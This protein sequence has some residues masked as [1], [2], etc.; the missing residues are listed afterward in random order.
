MT[1]A[2]S[3]WIPTLAAFAVRVMA[4]IALITTLTDFARLQQDLRMYF[5]NRYADVA[6][7]RLPDVLLGAALC[8]L[9]AL[10]APALAAWSQRGAGRTPG[11]GET[12]DRASR[13]VIMTMATA[14]LL[15]PLVRAP[16]AVLLPLLGYG[17]IPED[18]L[19]HMAYLNEPMLVALIAPIV[20]LLSPVLGAAL[21]AARRAL[22]RQA[23]T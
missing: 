7:E 3:V 20:I 14:S 12:I 15:I 17:D 16:E 22:Q 4:L 19:A 18:L 23:Y 9:L 10:L 13:A 6:L 11:Q 21:N 1:A 5:G 8:A 2:P